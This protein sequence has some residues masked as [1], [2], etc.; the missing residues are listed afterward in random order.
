MKDNIIKFPS[1]AE[2]SRQEQQEALR[3]DLEIIEG[4]LKIALEEL[5]I[6]NEDIIVLTDAYEKVLTELKAL[7][8][9]E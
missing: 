9:K 7:L 5:D 4:E 3:N 8:L 6:L 2:K 1:R